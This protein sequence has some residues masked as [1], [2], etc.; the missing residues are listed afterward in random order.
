M[1]DMSDYFR[2]NGGLKMWPKNYLKR[3]AE[4]CWEEQTAFTAHLATHVEDMFRR[5]VLN[6][7][8]EFFELWADLQ[9]PP[10]EYED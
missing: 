3:E 4:Y 7:R 1:K 2:R 9:D 10:V 6:K 5:K 8:N